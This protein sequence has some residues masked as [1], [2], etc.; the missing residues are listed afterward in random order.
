[1]ILMYYDGNPFLAAVPEYVSPG[2]KYQIIFW[3]A[4]KVLATKGKVL[5]NYQ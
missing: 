4:V 1:L 2:G 3:S 5:D